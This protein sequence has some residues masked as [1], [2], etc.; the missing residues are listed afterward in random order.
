MVEISYNKIKDTITCIITT[1][2]GNKVV[3]V[4]DN[5]NNAYN[6]ALDKLKGVK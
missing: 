5:K 6:N 4:G 1:K 3:G 2:N